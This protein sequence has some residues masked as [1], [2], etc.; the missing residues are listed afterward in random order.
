MSETK[1]SDGY[2]TY[3]R[4]EIKHALRSLEPTRYS[5]TPLDFKC[6]IYVIYICTHVDCR[7]N[8]LTW[9]I[10]KYVNAKTISDRKRIRGKSSG[11]D[12]SGQ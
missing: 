12:A 9:C 4:D 5:K 2:D 6:Y 7:Q 8:V 11:N 1:K 10:R 3:M